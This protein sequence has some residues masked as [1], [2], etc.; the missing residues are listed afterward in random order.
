MYEEKN[1]QMQ[2]LYVLYYSY[3]QISVDAEERI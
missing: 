3:V 2:I 1:Q